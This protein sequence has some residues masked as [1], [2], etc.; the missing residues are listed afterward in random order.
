MRG[1]YLD[2]LCLAFAGAGTNPY[3]DAPDPAYAYQYADSGP[4]QHTYADTCSHAPGADWTL[5]DGI[6]G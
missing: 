2:G 4:D 6:C 5:A 1:N 3:S